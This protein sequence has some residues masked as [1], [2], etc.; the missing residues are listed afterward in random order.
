MTELTYYLRRVILQPQAIL[1]MVVVAC[2]AVA[3][4]I[5]P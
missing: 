3:V 1:A 2:L 5:G 4:L